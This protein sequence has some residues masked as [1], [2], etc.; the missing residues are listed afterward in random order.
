MPV[1]TVDAPTETENA[2]IVGEISIHTLEDLKAR[3]PHEVEFLLAKVVSERYFEGKPWRFPEIL[4]I[5]R[6]WL[7]ECLDLKDKVFPQYLLFVELA[8]RAAEKIYRSI[9][10]VAESSE[11]LLKPIL[12]P[13]NTVGS[14]RYVQFDTT[15]PVRPTQPDKSHISHVVLDSR[16]EA[17]LAQSL[18]EMAEVVSYAKNQSLGFYVPYSL[19]GRNRRYLPDYLVRVDDGR[20]P[21]DPLNLIIEVTG[22]KDTDKQAKVDTARDL[23]VPAVNNERAFGRWA[24]YEV[25]DPWNAQMEIWKM[26]RSLQPYRAA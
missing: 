17:K 12:A 11:A 24:F 19:D 16:W 22:E 10:A 7:A 13:Y 18:E 21:E 1:S 26:L 5:T 4:K 14:T 25:R 3:R 20:G 6:R 2:P 15:K 9:V 8:H 23:W